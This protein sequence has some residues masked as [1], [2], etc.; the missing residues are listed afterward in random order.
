MNTSKQS[1]QCRSTATM[2]DMQDTQPLPLFPH[3]RFGQE[4]AQERYR[5][6]KTF[7]DI[8]G[9]RFLFVYLSDE[10]QRLKAMGKQ[11]VLASVSTWGGSHS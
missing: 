3:P 7:S 9:V 6:L 4:T 1:S 11:T 5:R 10:K 8:T 2:I